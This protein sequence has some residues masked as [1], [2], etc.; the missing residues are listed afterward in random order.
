MTRTQE[1]LEPFSAPDNPPGYG[2]PRRMLA[3]WG[4]LCGTWLTPPRLRRQAWEATPASSSHAASRS[5][6]LAHLAVTRTLHE[7]NDRVDRDQMRSS[8]QVQGWRHRQSRRLCPDTLHEEGE[9]GSRMAGP[10]DD[11]DDGDEA[12]PKGTVESDLLDDQCRL[13]IM[14]WCQVDWRGREEQSRT[15][16]WTLGTS[17][18]PHALPPRFFCGSF[19]SSQPIGCSILFPNSDPFEGD[20]EDK[21]LTV[22]WNSNTLGGVLSDVTAPGPLKDIPRANNPDC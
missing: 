15:T 22:G 10:T 7:I 16:C 17:L 4:N 19:T 3:R 13:A 5:S 1:H 11:A 14:S 8:K 2:S 21:A 6:G 20:M 9:V 18:P 12:I